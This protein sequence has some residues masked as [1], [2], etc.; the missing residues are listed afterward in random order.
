MSLF[1]RGQAKVFPLEWVK[2]CIE[3]YTKDHGKAP[4]I[5]VLA[6]EDYLDYHLNCTLAQAGQLGVKVTHGQYLKSGEI[7]LAMG[8]KDEVQD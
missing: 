6:T 1:T 5:L 3:T 7:D 2:H 8:I 4:K